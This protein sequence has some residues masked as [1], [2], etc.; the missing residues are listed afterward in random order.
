MRRVFFTLRRIETSLINFFFVHN[1][2]KTRRENAIM[3]RHLFLTLGLVFG[4]APVCSGVARV[5]KHPSNNRNEAD[6]M[7]R[8]VQMEKI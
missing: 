8:Q 6:S 1:R 5:N 4:F 2:I 7:R 3:K